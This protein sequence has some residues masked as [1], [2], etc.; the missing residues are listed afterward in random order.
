MRTSAISA[1]AVVTLGGCI[2][3][4]APVRE[5]VVPR[6]AEPVVVAPA[7]VAQPPPVRP[8]P[9]PARVTPRID[10]TSLASFRSS[11]QEMA[12]SLSESDRTKLNRAATLIAFA[13][14]GG[15]SVPLSLKDSPIVPE[16]IRDQIHGMTFAQ[17]VRLGAERAAITTP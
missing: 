17:I 14:Y 15:V 7:A 12:D 11:W 4:P 9:R 1:V 2:S 16:V 13:P 8:A 10:S 5:G 3:G 6:A